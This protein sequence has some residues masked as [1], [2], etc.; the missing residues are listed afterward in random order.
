MP[1]LDTWLL[2]LRHCANKNQETCLNEMNIHCHGLYEDNFA[3]PLM[4]NSKF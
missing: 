2:E 1:T 3:P 4:P